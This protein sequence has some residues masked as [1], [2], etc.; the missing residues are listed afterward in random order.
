MI[1]Y[2]EKEEETGILAKFENGFRADQL[3]KVGL[4]KITGIDEFRACQE[5]L[6]RVTTKAPIMEYITDIVRKTR[7]WSDLQ[8]GGGVRATISLF[9]ASKARAML[10]GRDFVT[11]DDVKGIVFPVLRHR[12]ILRPEAEIEGM[13]PDEIIQSVLNQ[14]KIPR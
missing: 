8:I 9:L 5:A 3:E 13:Q 14:I 12:I 1:P 10:G 2:P 7:N 6:R 11:P 4:Q